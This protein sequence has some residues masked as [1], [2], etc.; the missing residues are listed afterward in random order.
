MRAEFKGVTMS[1]P[2]SLEN[3]L[4]DSSVKSDFQGLKFFQCKV[5]KFVVRVKSLNPIFGFWDQFMVIIQRGSST[6]IETSTTTQKPVRII[7]DPTGIVQ[8]AKLLKQT[9][10]QDGEEG[11]V[12]L[13]QEYMKK[14]V[15]DVGEDED[16]K[17]GSWVSDTN[18]VNANGG[19]SCSPNVIGDLT[20]TMKDHSGT[21]PG[22]IH[23]KVIDKGGYGKD[24]TVGAALILV[25]VSVFSPKPSTH[26]LN[27]TI[28]NV[29]KVFRKDTVLG[30][31]S[32]VGGSGML[33]EEE[34]IVKL[35]KEEEMADLELQDR[36]KCAGLRM[37]NSNNQSIDSKAA[38]IRR[39]GGCYEDSYVADMEENEGNGGG[40]LGANKASTYLGPLDLVETAC[41]LEVEAMRAL[42]LV[43]VEAGCLLGP[44][45]V[46]GVSLNIFISASVRGYLTS[47]KQTTS[48]SQKKPSSLD[49]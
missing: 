37:T 2:Q 14:V 25:N 36:I 45:D 48:L 43:E 6:R 18:Y 30:S 17:S 34:E 11:C 28:R 29:V 35:M 47:L 31:G 13:T 39:A 24:V 9:N 19:I 21:I 33:I 23:D 44:L 10:I 41:A 4:E 38:S 8:A 3:L 49:T 7:P 15:E 32:D 12:M 46:V 16:F 1:L 20:V 5:W 22:T 27:N 26:Y 42:D 40:E